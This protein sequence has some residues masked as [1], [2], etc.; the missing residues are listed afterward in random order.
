VILNYVGLVKIV[1]TF[2][3]GVDTVTLRTSLLEFLTGQRHFCHRRGGGSNRRPAG[4][5][6]GPEEKRS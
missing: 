5:G 6:K 4:V 3:A 2:S 1:L